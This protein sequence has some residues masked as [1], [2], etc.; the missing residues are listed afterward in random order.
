MAASLL[1]TL[2]RQRRR[3]SSSDVH[4]T[5][6]ADA[7]TYV[8]LAAAAAAAEP[9]KERPKEELLNWARIATAAAEATFSGGEREFFCFLDENKK[10]RR[11]FV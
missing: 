2:R 5:V 11:L 1:G 4:S 6:I 7:A 8:V 10:R 3:Q 9:D